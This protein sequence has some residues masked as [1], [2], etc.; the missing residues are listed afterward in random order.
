MNIEDAISSAASDLRS[1]GVPDPLRDARTLLSSVLGRD[2]AF[3]IAHPEYILS[4]DERRGLASAV[5]RRSAR[6]PLQYIVGHQEFYGLRFRVTPE[7]LIPRPETEAVVETVIGLLERLPEPR[8]FE[9]GVGSGCISVSILKHL[10]GAC[11]VGSDI[12]ETAIAVARENAERHGVLSRFELVCTD[13]FSDLASNK[14]YDVIVSNPPYVDIREVASLQSEV[15]DF[16]PR[17][18]LTDNADGLSIIRRIVESSPMHLKP[19]GALVLE[20]GFRQSQA[21]GEMFERALWGEP[22][23]RPDLSGIP[24]VVLAFLDDL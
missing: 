3:I 1:S 19:R 9:V 12:S 24:R 14:R 21:V 2:L 16:E 13:I 22:E 18:A 8:F 15:R 20:I 10:P 7:V 11:A 5:F 23:F 17:I 6:E 4:D